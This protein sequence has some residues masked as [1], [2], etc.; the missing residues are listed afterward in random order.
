MADLPPTP[1]PPPLW[2]P[3][4]TPRR[5]RRWRTVAWL[6]AITL[7]ASVAIVGW[8]RPLQEH[9]PSP[10]PGAPTYTSQQIADARAAVC[11]AFGNVDHALNLAD[12][13]SSGSGDPTAQLAVATSTRQV[14]D[15]GSRYLLTK[16]AAEPAT[17]PELASA[18]RKQTDAYQEVVMRYL[19][20]LDYSDPGLKSAG[21]ASNEATETIRRICE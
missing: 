8:L 19:D 14:L 15:F 13:R 21:S 4:G 10:A 12:N 2:P 11:G 20:G 6:V 1:S 16:L 5:P 17:P 7:V 9:K 18:V 3:V